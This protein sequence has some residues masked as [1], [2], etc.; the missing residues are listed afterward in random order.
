MTTPWRLVAVA[1]AA[2]ALIGA[3]YGLTPSPLYPPGPV[4]FVPGTASEPGLA[5]RNDENTGLT[6][7]LAEHLAIVTEGVERARV[8]GV[9][10]ILPHTMAIRFAHSTAGMHGGQRGHV[11]VLRL[12]TVGGS[13]SSTDPDGNDRIYLGHVGT[14][15]VVEGLGGEIFRVGL[16]VD[17]LH[18]TGRLHVETSFALG[19]HVVT[20]GNNG[21]SGTGNA[22][23]LSG[24]RALYF[25]DCQD[26]DGCPITLGTSGLVAGAIVRV[27]SLGL[28]THA[29]SFADSGSQ[30]LA[31]AFTMG[32][33]DTISFVFVRNRSGDV[34]WAETGRSDN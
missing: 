22:E 8:H 15:L 19:A 31:G 29:V 2:A 17:V 10:L 5:F 4:R 28:A 13:G 21:V 34:Y 32:P 3:S 1:L 33:T 30:H 23:S 18:V 14:V 6:S 27:V 20:V 9:G 11:T 16:P 25:V 24:L 7:P 26:G 12:S